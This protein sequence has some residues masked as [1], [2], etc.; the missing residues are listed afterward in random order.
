MLQ[1]P[2]LT[3]VLE[4]PA[5]DA[6]GKAVIACPVRES[7]CPIGN[8]HRRPRYAGRLHRRG[9]PQHGTGVPRAGEG[10]LGIRKPHLY[11]H[12]TEVL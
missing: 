11:P 9:G 1:H 5:V 10:T 4:H 3:E 2:G 8:P 7:M 12:A 6:L